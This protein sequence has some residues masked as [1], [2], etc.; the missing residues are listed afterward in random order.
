MCIKYMTAVKKTIHLWRKRQSF[1]EAIANIDYDVTGEISKTH[2]DGQNWCSTF[3]PFHK[4]GTCRRST[5]EILSSIFWGREGSR[6]QREQ[7]VLQKF[8]NPGNMALVFSVILSAAKAYLF[9][10]KHSTLIGY[11][12]DPR[13]ITQLKRPLNLI[14]ALQL[15]VE[16]LD[17]NGDY[18][19]RT[20]TKALVK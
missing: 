2:Y 9:L 10:P 8:M 17:I 20:S 14:H 5:K 1:P 15:F 18:Q 19:A 7:N 3:Q 4:R 11:K 16:E 12:V 13:W 6:A